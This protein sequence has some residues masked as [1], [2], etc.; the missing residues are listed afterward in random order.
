MFLFKFIIHFCRIPGNHIRVF[1]PG[2]EEKPADI[3]KEIASLQE[4]MLIVIPA[5]VM[6]LSIMLWGEHNENTDH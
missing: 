5:A 1:F 6:L 3:E 2:P 4:N